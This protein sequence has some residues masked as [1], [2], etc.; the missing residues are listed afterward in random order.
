V[1][2]DHVDASTA[3]RDASWT[4]SQSG[5]AAT[6]SELLHP[7]V[8]RGAL[9]VSVGAAGVGSLP[10]VAVVAEG[11]VFVV[12]VVLLVAG[13]DGIRSITE[14]SGVTGSLASQIDQ[15]T[16]ATR[17]TTIGLTLAALWLA[18][19]A[20]RSLTKVL[21]ACAAGA[22]GMGGR[23]GKAT[24]KM[25]AS[26]TTLILGI[27]VAAGVLNRIKEEQ[28]FAVV[29]TSWIV[30]AVVYS[31]GW[32]MV[33]LSLPRRT[34]DPGAALPGAVVLGFALAALQWV[35]QFY[36]PTRL[37]HSTAMSGTL[38]VSVAALGYMFLIGRLMVSSLILDAVIY[39]RVGSVSNLVFSLPVLQR[40][41]RRFPKVARFFDLDRAGASEPAPPGPDG[42]VVDGEGNVPLPRDHAPLDCHRRHRGR[43]HQGREE[44]DSGWRQRGTR[45]PGAAPGGPPRPIP[46]SL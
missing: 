32:F 12:S 16:N 10:T 42:Q 4:A 11:G 6:L 35:M 17:N 21:A 43:R 20:G 37:E 7:L 26:V 38:G 28:G 27:L 33:S 31:A 1:S 13:Q 15:S 30:T 22:W 5:L 24:L 9:V 36:L 3:S 18:V 23:E 19:W 25:A 41:P 39:D 45:E 14:Q 46:E 40:I 29:T 34:R 44:G 2:N 8:D